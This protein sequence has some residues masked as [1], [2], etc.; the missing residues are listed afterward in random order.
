MSLK[1]DS[2][3]AK[4]SPPQVPP[5]ATHD[6]SG[7]VGRFAP[8]PSGPLH[9]GSL[10]TALASFLDIRAQRGQWL[11]RIDDLDTPR[12]T[13]G[14]EAAILQTLEA[15]HLH[16]DGTLTRQSDHQE[17]YELA[18]HELARMEVLFFCDCSRKSLKGATT[19]PGT[20]RHRH[21]SPT[22]LANHL[23]SVSGEHKYAIRLQMPDH[24]LRFND[25]LQGLQATHLAREGGDYIVLRRDGLIS[26]QLAVVVDDA[27]TAVNQVVRGADL[28]PTTARQQQLHEQLGSTAPSWLHLPILLNQRNTKLSKQAHSMAVT[29]DHVT[30]NLCIALQLLGQQP[31]PG[32]TQWPAHELIDWATVNWS[33]DRLPTGESLAHFFGW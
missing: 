13:P 10:I 5:W 22:E 25:Q 7:P 17:H 15:H 18:L 3:T 16:W 30:T 31:P 20:C 29:T 33:R 28:L 32:A 12:T 23:G 9:F 1:S 21:C 11:L 27:L 4:P 6:S 26:Y 14:S 24:E 8:S 2:S 19:Y